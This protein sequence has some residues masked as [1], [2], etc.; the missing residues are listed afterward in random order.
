MRTYKKSTVELSNRLQK[1]RKQSGLTQEQLA[2]KSGV[3]RQTII[4]IEKGK[5]APSLSLALIFA[6]NFKTN[7]EDIFYL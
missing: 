5:Y 4:S 1:F 6:K 7:V 2:Q 3:T